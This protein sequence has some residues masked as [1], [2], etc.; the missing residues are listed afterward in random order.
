MKKIALALA[1]FAAFGSAASAMSA[2]GL[3]T[4][5]I[6][7]I[8]SIQP[9]ADLSALTPAEIAALQSALYGDDNKKGSKI[10]SILN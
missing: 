8:R 7:E 6:T 1:A 9:N 4:F 2:P 10:R 5:E 3:S